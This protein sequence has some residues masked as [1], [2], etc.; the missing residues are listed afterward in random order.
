[1]SYFKEKYSEGFGGD[2]NF[3][4]RQSNVPPNYQNFYA[5]RTR[6]RRLLN[7]LRRHWFM[8]SLVLLGAV[9]LYRNGIK[10]YRPSEK[11][12]ISPNKSQPNNVQGSY[13][14]ADEAK[15]ANAELNIGNVF[16][17]VKPDESEKTV[18][19]SDKKSPKKVGKNVA[20]KKNATLSDLPP[21]NVPEIVSYCK[22]YAHVAIAERKKFGIPSSLILANAVR[23]SFAGQRDCAKRANNHFALPAQDWNGK[24]ETCANGK[25]RRYES[26]WLSFRDHSLF[27]TGEKFAGI[28]QKYQPTEYKSWA[29]AIQDA[30]YPAQNK[31]LAAELI[32]IIEKYQLYR[33]DKL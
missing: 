4:H 23:Q 32:L 1:M 15:E 5:S 19:K 21:L 9:A 33:L 29:K 13:T 24:I 27:L 22:K 31:Q 20:P 17:D 28:K 2:G 26:V 3:Y 6:S 11:S 12:S 14:A 18:E 7:W 8:V 10:L 25:M 16:E 30:G